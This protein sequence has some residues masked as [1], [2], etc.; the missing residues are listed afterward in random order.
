MKIS[1]PSTE[2]A[3]IARQA[4][5]YNNLAD[6]IHKA[7]KDFLDIHKHYRLKAIARDYF[8]QVC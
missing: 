4:S 8:A 3:K 6:T 7:C 2:S 5:H 1:F